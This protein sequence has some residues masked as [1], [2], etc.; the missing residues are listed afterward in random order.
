MACSKTTPYGSG[1]NIVDSDIWKYW[2]NE[3]D[4]GALVPSWSTS[5][6]GSSSSQSSQNYSGLPT[7]YRDTL[8]S[9]VVPQLSDSVS[10]M[11][12][13]ADAYAQQAQNK[14]SYMMQNALQPAIRQAIN[15]LAGR[16]VLSS[17]VASDT[18]GNVASDAML[19]AGEKGYEAAM[20]AALMKFSIPEILAQIAD[21]G[22][23]TQGT[24]SGSSSSSNMSY[25]EDPSS[26]Y[27]LMAQTAVYGGDTGSTGG[28]NRSAGSSGGYQRSS[29]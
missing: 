24:S 27:N 2:R 29:Y 16:G 7:D 13:N 18:I 8:L 25:S 28:Y 6:G 12:G 11:M 3:G 1:S 5:T 15:N 14:Y 9:G 10:K 20:Q 22:R 26:I 19:Q 4:S 21:L 17:T 23:Y